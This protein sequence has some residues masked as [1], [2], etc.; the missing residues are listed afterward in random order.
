MQTVVMANHKG[1]VG[2]TTSAL[3]LGPALAERGLRVLLVDLDPQANLSEGFGLAEQAGPRVEDLLVA[4]GLP[5]LAEAAV[6]VDD[7]LWVL[8][9]SWALGSA[10]SA[11]AA[12]GE[13]YEHRLRE[14]LQGSS[15]AFDVALVDTPPSIGMWSGLALL[16]ADAVL[17]PVTPADYDQMGAQ[18]QLAF[19]EQAIRPANPDV[20]VLGVL[21]TKAQAR[22]RVLRDV[23]RALQ[24]DD[25]PTLPVDVPLQ[26][27]V[28][29]AVRTGRP[30]FMLEPDGRVANAYRAIAAH[31]ADALA[32]DVAAV[33]A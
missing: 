9:C 29:T 17:V 10:D 12:R 2:K 28:A 22:W 3:N 32:L 16:A 14:L 7:G 11:L 5:S 21:V 19:I 26:I 13:G 25:M 15:E 23:K 4:D 1:G 27:R 24:R 6:H 8:P 31:I 18:K 30:T 20:R 33:A